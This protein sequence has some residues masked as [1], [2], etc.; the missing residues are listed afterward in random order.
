[1]YEDLITQGYVVIPDFLN[2]QHLE[3][4]RGDHARDREFHNGNYRTTIASRPVFD[5]LRA[6]LVDALGL[7]RAQTTLTVDTPIPSGQYTDTAEISFGWHQDHEAFYQ[8]QQNQQYLNFYI[9]IIKPD[10]DLS[11][12]SVVPFAALSAADP[13]CMDRVINHGAAVYTSGPNT[14]VRDDD[15]GGDYHI[16]CD[17]DSLAVHPRL[18]P[19]DLLLMRGDLIHRTQDNDTQRVAVSFRCT[20]GSALISRSR[21]LEGCDKKREIMS[22]NRRVYDHMRA[23]FAELGR[24]Q[25]SAAAMFGWDQ[26]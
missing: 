21:L 10:P 5:H 11:G 6:L 20:D 1:M 7:V 9:P 23:R 16:N 24:D 18:E 8:L 25:V 19:G 13:H 12:L 26:S 15:L 17:I 3:L 4:L 22:N 2:S 14:A